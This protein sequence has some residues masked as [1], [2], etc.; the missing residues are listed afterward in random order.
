MAVHGHGGTGR[1]EEAELS[2]CRPVVRRQPVP[3]AE[4]FYLNRMFAVH[5]EAMS[6]AK[7]WPLIDFLTLRATRPE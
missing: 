1:P 6:A 3:G 4:A 7:S 2:A 5:F